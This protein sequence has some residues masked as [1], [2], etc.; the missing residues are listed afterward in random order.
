[1]SRARDNADLGDNYGTFSGTIG[2]A[3][4]PAGMVLKTETQSFNV[5]GTYDTTTSTSYETTGLAVSITPLNTNTKILVLGSFGVSSNSSSAYIAVN[6]KRTGSSVSD[7]YLL[8]ESY[9]AFGRAYV[10]GGTISPV[11]IDNPSNS[12]PTDAITYTVHIKVNSGT[13]YFG[14]A[15]GG[16]ITV[17]E[18]KA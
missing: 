12:N 6:I 8:N 17:C 2:N 5:S 14:S 16:S 11:Y 10:E 7:V 18:I 13:A 9:N 3:T 1:M 15:S 4:F